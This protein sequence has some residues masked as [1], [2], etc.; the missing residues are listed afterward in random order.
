MK[1]K[2]KKVDSLPWID[3]LCTLI[4]LN[5]SYEQDER[6]SLI[7]YLNRKEKTTLLKCAAFSL[8]FLNI[9][10]IRIC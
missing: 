2:S 5:Y 7:Q 6:A 4:Q 3:F 8:Q 9:M 10:T 1:N